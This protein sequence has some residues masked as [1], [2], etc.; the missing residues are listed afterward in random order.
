MSPPGAKDAKLALQLSCFHCLILPRNEPM[1]IQP[2][3]ST[4][5]ATYTCHRSRS[6]ENWRDCLCSLDIRERGGSEV[7]GYSI[8][9]ADGD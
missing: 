7:R 9:P 6:T 5:Q 1:G 2:S 8:Y 3:L 4:S